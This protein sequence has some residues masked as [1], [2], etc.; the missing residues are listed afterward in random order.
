MNL[1]KIITPATVLLRLSASDKDGVIEEIVNFMDSAG[2]ISDRRA[3]L[4]CIQ[5]RERKMSTGMTGGLAIP[6]GKTGSVDSLVACLALKPEGVEFGALD[7]TPCTVF[8]ATVSPKNRTGPHIQ[9]LAEISR[10][11]TD[12]ARVQRILEARTEAEAV[13]LLFG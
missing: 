10:L 7:G 11:L 6:H 3:V 9:F 13:E 8:V 4:R 12:P 1:R 2:L 5:E